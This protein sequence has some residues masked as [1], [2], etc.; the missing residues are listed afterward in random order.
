MK[1]RNVRRIITKLQRHGHAPHSYSGRGMF[2]AECV[3]I[4]LDHRDESVRRLTGSVPRWDSMGRQV[5][6][7][8]PDLPW[9]RHAAE[10]RA[11]DWGG[12]DADAGDMDGEVAGGEE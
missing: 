9:P 10:V 5:V 3:A 4:T 6:A 11:A 7:Y 1:P 8:W 12:D 2:G